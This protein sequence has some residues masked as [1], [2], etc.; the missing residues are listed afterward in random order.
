MRLSISMIVLAGLL[1][2]G[3]TTIESNQAKQTSTGTPSGEVQLPDGVVEPSEP[4][5]GYHA[6][7]I[8]KGLSCPLCAHNID[9]QLMDVP[10]VKGVA[11]DLGSGTADVSFQTDGCVTYA[12]LMQAVR[13]SGFTTE[14]IELL[15]EGAGG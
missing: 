13:D 5:K 9:K 8:V 7:L 15:E 11:V 2:A 12:Q 3:C 1:L 6:R 14:R 4:V 10:G